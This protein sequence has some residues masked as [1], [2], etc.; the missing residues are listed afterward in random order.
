MSAIRRFC[1][2]TKLGNLLIIT[3]VLLCCLT[4]PLAAAEPI[5][6]QL[7]WLHQFQFAGYYMAKEK[8]F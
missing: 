7:R 6:L 5:R 2:A 3:T 1:R 8:G 4:S